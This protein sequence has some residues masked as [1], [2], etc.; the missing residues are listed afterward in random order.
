VTVLG[1]ADSYATWAAGW[2][3]DIGA[4][5][6]DYDGD[7]LDNLMEYALGGN[8]TNADAA[9]VLPLLHSSGNDFYYTHNER[10]DDTSLTYTV[11]WSDD[12]SVMSWKT[13]GV[14]FFGE[15]AS[16]FP[17]VLKTVTNLIPTLGK[18]QQFIRLKIEKE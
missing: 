12:L 18:D 8:P 1:V 13:D 2:V 15:S 11:E 9:A 16:A 6:D 14:T 5:T 7:G 4:S 3:V 10:T 17:D